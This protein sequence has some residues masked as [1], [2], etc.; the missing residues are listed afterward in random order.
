MS[1]VSF[2]GPRPNI[3]DLEGTS[4]QK[5]LEVVSA[6]PDERR[7]GAHPPI[8]AVKDND[9]SSITI[10]ITYPVEKGAA[11]MGARARRA[12]APKPKSAVRRR[13]T[14]SSSCPTARAGPDRIPIPSLLATSAVHHHLIK[15]G[16]RTSVGLV[17]ETGEAHEMQPVLHA[18]GLR[19]GGDQPLPRLRDARQ[20]CCP[21]STRRSTPEDAQ[22]ELHQ[23]HRQ[24]HPE[25]DGQDG[26]LDL[27]V[28]LRRADLRRGRAAHELRR[29]STSPARTRRS[30]ASACARSRARRSNA[31][32]PRSATCPCSTTRSMSAASTP[33][34][35]A[36]KRTCGGRTS[37]PI[38]SMPCAATWTRC[39]IASLLPNRS[40][41]S[42][43]S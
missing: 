34:A 29:R 18:C 6:D 23:G 22:E 42:P 40:T 41:T 8:G 16:L 24:G 3:L 11:G 43:S 28:L 1:L 21:T 4:K 12:S 35:C 9:F 7:S 38:C 19:R 2:I 31:T 37:S 32:R 10:D 14:T 33:T 25:G 15:Q 20:R 30:K 13:N 5:R 17:V 39:A 36:A 27:S 26:H